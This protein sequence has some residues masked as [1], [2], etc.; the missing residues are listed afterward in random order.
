MFSSADVLC[1]IVAGT[2]QQSLSR[3]NSAQRVFQAFGG[4]VLIGLGAKLALQRG[5]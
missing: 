4:S 3:S 2:V 1:V 5:S